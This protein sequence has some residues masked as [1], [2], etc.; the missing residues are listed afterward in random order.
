MFKRQKADMIMKMMKTHKSNIEPPVRLQ[1]SAECLA[2]PDKSHSMSPPRSLMACNVSAKLS[3][4]M[5]LVKSDIIESP[6]DPKSS[7]PV[8]SESVS[9]YGCSYLFSGAS[10]FPS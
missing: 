3:A 10:G 2:P 4:S 9:Q 8:G 7:T 6:M 5:P 1:T